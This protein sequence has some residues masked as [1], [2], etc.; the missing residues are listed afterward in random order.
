MDFDETY[1]LVVV[2]GV[3]FDETYALVVQWSTV[4]MLLSLSLTLGLKT[5][6]V[7]YTNAFVQAVIDKKVYCE[8]PQEFIGPDNDQYVLIIII[9]LK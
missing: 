4:R 1:A 2:Y 7:Y 3:D 5:R 8:L 9:I 6:Q